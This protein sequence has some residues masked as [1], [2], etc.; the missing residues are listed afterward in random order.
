MKRP[1]IL[2]LLLMAGCGGPEVPP[3][4]DT[5]DAG[6]QLSTALEAWRAGEPYGSL[7]S[8]NPPII[9]TEPLWEGGTRLVD[10]E[11]GPV[12]LNGRQGR[13]T[14]RLTLV[15]KDGKKSQRSIGYQIDT[16]PRVVIVRESLG[17]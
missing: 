12:E 13:C 17:I 4:V 11:L 1:F 5:A 8:R 2:V 3:A 15:G 7:A 16:V 10:Y 6:R 14:A 9:F